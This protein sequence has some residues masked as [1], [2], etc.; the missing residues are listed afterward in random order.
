MITRLPIGATVQLRAT[1]VDQYHRPIS[2]SNPITYTSDNSAV[3]SVD[4]VGRVTA[5]AEGSCNITATSGSLSDSNP[6]TVY[7]PVVSGLVV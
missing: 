7:T 5:L 6:L 4:S 3:A 2:A 1:F